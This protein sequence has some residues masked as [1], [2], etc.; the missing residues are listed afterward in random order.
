MSLLLAAVGAT[1]AALLELTLGPYLRVGDAHPHLVLL[2]GV[3]WTVASG[4]D[5]GLAWAFA[6]GIALD[7]LAPR[8]MGSSAFA[9]LISLSGV[10]L[11]ARPLARVRVLLP[12]PLVALFSFVNSVLLL[13]LYGALL[14]PPAVSDPVSALLP[15]VVYDMVLAAI[16]GPLVV[17]IHDR[18]TQEERVDW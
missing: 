12:I 8:P 13:I 15:G 18:A 11:L 4:V 7:V 1:V 2:L 5:A 16:L 17:S 10:A 3:I 14:R 6:G 9:L